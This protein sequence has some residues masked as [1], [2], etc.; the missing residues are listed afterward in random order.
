M[1]ETGSNLQSV[2]SG[3]KNPSLRTAARVAIA[4]LSLLAVAVATAAVIIPDSPL[5][6]V[7]G[8]TTTSSTTTTSL[9]TTTTGQPTT[10]VTSTHVTRQ[11]SSTAGPTATFTS[12]ATAPSITTTTAPTTTT[13]TRPPS[14]TTT[15]PSTTTTAHPDG[16]VGL[17]SPTGVPVRLKATQDDMWLVVTPCGYDLWVRGGT[18]IYQTTV[19]LDPGHGGS[20][21]IGATGPNGL[22]EKVVNLRIAKEAQRILNERKISNVLT[23]TSD[24]ASILSARARFA[25]A[26]RAEIM[27]SIHHNAPTPPPSSKPG[28]EVYIQTGSDKSRRL[29]GLLYQ[30]S[31]AALSQFD[32]QWSSTAG[33]GVMTVRLPSGADAYGILRHPTTPTALLEFGRL[34]HAPEA[35]LFATDAYVQAAARSIVDAVHAYLFTDEPGSGWAAGRVRTPRMGLSQ[36]ECVDP[37]LE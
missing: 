20:I 25:D 33:A 8:S 15:Q 13:T 21:D 18:P 22:E 5:V 24:Y 27:V 1:E 4:T 2:P 12:S 11:P 35:Q 10:H 14:T 34:S 19:V 32:I 26:V 37:I 3:P 28:N 30:Y 31:M 6:E 9:P 36:S 17:V 16:I 29:G 23:R 7:V